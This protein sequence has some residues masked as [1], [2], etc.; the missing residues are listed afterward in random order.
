MHILGRCWFAEKL[1]P[2]QQISGN[3]AEKSAKVD[4]IIAKKTALVQQ[5]MEYV[6]FVQSQDMPVSAF[7]GSFYISG[8]H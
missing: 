5:V 8:S 4:E 7:P 1:T 2:Q 6:Q 3:S